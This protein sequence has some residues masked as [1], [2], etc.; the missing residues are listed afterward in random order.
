MTREGFSF[1][2]DTDRP[3]CGTNEE[4]WTSHHDEWSTSAYGTDARPPGTPEE[5]EA[6]RN[7]DG[8]VE[9]SWTAPGDDW[10][11]GS[12]ES[13]RILASAN[14]I[15][16]PTDG[17][18]IRER[19]ADEQAGEPVAESFSEAELGDARHLAVLYRD[20]AGNWGR[21]AGTEV[22]GPGRCANLIEGGP[23]DDIL[24]GT[25]DEDE[26]RGRGGADRVSGRGADDCLFA[27]AGADRV[28]GG[29]GED[30]VR[31]GD[32]ED[33]IK[34]DDGDRDQV[35]CGTARDL[36]IVDR[37]DRVRGCERVRLR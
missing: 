2:W 20:E 23:R 14:P 33:R 36:A 10:L 16:Q 29:S 5:V 15:D 25:E 3:A 17:A 32:G 7:P 27:G 19:S 4:S 8:S 21:L 37:Q 35:R 9:L 31:G 24:R 12:A 22:P 6:V 18:V 11:C 30:E 34:A 28:R 26:I 1:L 13:V